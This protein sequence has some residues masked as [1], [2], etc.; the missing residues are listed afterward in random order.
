M[1][2]TFEISTSYQVKYTNKTPVP[3]SEIVKSLQAYERFLRLTPAFIEQAYEGI[4][5]VDV[6][7]NVKSL[8]SGSLIEDY[9]IRYIFKGE[10]NYEQAKQI[11]LKIMDNSEA[12]RL[13][14][15][16][17]VGSILTYGVVKSMSSNSPSIQIENVHNSIINVGAKTNLSEADIN[18]VLESLPDKKRIAKD[19]IDILSPTRTDSSASIEV[20][21]FNELTFT[22][23]AIAEAPKEY[24]SPEPEEQTTNYTNVDLVIYASDRDKLAQGWAGLAPGI[25][26]KRIKFELGDDVDPKTLHGRVRVKADIS[27][28]SKYNRRKRH[29]EPT[30]I[31]IKKFS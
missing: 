16:V 2:K 6:E 17:G 24:I 21:G 29:F 7:V 1:D 10:E 8:E 20:A 23:E 9:V 5:I 31:I 22:P 15:A 4:K 14:V 3:I 26:D 13:I 19:S 12:L 27:V 25:V 11:F 18:S 30:Q 28:I